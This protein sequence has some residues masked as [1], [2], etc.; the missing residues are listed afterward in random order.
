M[1]DEAPNHKSWF[2]T[3]KILTAVGITIATVA[4]FEG[5]MSDGVWVYSMAVF[6]AGHH[7]ADLVKAWKGN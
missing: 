2:T 1:S 4:L 7:A 5:K 3:R 6:I